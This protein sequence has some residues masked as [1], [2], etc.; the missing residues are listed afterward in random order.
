MVGSETLGKA[1][2]KRIQ[3]FEVWCYRRMLKIPWMDRVTNEEVI[4][5]M[6]ETPCLWKT[7]QKRRDIWI[8]HIIRQ[9]G[10]VKT[11]LEGSV[12]GRNC[13]GRPRLEYIRQVMEDTGCHTYREMKR[14][15]EDREAWRAAANQPSG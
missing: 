10:L 7:L 15:T 2:K 6:K 12:E 4:R 1:E 14:L 5:R 11:I 13:R 9:E 8:G 3:A